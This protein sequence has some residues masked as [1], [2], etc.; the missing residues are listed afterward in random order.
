MNQT[1]RFTMAYLHPRYW[2]TWFGLF[3]L[4]SLVQL[5]YPVLTRIGAWAGRNSRRF[6]R[7]REDIARQNIA[8]CFPELAACERDK[9]IADNFISLGMAL[10]ETGMAW[11]WSDRRLRRW[12]DVEGLHN[13][14]AAQRENRGVLVVGVH[15]M[16][17]ELGGRMMG[18]CK[19]MSAVYRR[20]NN[21]LLE[22]AQT[23]GRMRSNKKMIDRRHLKEIVNA[24][25]HGEAVWF[26][27]DQDYGAKGSSFVPFFG[28]PRVATTNGPFVISRLSNAA[29][30]TIT[31]IRKPKGAGYRLIIEPELEGFPKEDGVEAASWMNRVIERE[32]M[33]APEQYLWI[34]RRFKTRPPGAASLYV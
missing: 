15:F 24:L 4:W 21:G 30:L 14:M 8:L 1:Q 22:W 12:F 7:R 23:R 10:V 31:L 32:I 5:P 26:A 9:L 11:F 27:P 34:H 2:L 18:L 17:L 16:S 33:R 19:P 28:V 6:L 3:C 13:L 29:M 25:K 20:H